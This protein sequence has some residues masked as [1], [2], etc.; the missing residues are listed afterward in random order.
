M[1]RMD[2]RDWTGFG[3]RSWEVP[4]GVEVQPSKTVWDALQLLI[5]PVILVGVTLAWSAGF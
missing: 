2:W 3:P 4:E 5:V 1:T